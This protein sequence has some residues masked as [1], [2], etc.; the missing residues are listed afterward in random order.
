MPQDIQS[1]RGRRSLPGSGT[2]RA[3][4]LNREPPHQTKRCF[5]LPAHHLIVPFKNTSLTF[6]AKKI[7]TV[8]VSRCLMCRESNSNYNSRSQ[9]QSVADKSEYIQQISGLL[10]SKDF[11]DRIKGI[12]QLVADCQYNPNMVINSMFPVSLSTFSISLWALLSV[13][14]FFHWFFHPSGVR[15]LQGQTARVQQQGQPVRPG[16][17]AENHP[18]AEGES[19]PSGQHSRAGYRGQSPQLQKQRHLLCCYWNYECAY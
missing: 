13:F 16:V 11:R 2:V 7:V 14:V 5:R 3:S 12:D 10:A 15:C 17:P 4:S 1:A 6:V 19:V 8:F 9:A 18:L